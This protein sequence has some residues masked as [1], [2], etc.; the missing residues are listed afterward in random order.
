MSAGRLSVDSAMTSVPSAS[1]A[2]ITTTGELWA[3]A[4]R[5][6]AWLDA[7]GCDS[8]D[9]YD[10]WGTRY[11]RWARRRYYN[12]RRLGGALIA[13]I[14]FIEVICPSLRKLFVSKQRFPTADAQLGLACLN[15]YEARRRLPS[16]IRGPLPDAT[17]SSWL[18][19]AQELAT[20]ILAQ[21]VPGYSG[22]CWGY[23]FD[24]QSVNG[25]VPKSTPH[26]TATPYCYELFAKLWD[27]TGDLSYLNVVRSI[28]AFV[29]RDLKDTPA[30]NDS[31]AS[32]YTPHDHSKVINAS[33]YRAF[34][35]LDAARRFEDDGLKNR[36]LS[37][38]RFILQNQRPD[39]S[40]LYAVDSPAEAFID[41]FHTCFVLKNLYKLNR[42]LRSVEVDG[43][44][45]RGYAWYRQAL[46]DDQDQPRSFAIA[47]RAQIV[48][49][50]MYDVAEA[51]SL[52]VLLRQSIPEGFALADALAARLI[53]HHQLR[54][55]HWLTR[56]YRGGIRHTLPFLRWPQS[57]LFLAV[58]NLLAAL[59]SETPR[60]AQ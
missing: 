34:V 55:G 38:L 20:D 13:P 41:H 21:S 16:E 11:G 3:A 47:P 46:F 9:P 15:L 44:I 19:R 32:S 1:S 30:G 8:Y 28:T 6:T 50:E 40:W 45:R 39:G 51:I 52:G 43:A 24:W 31:A 14:L 54:A 56:V 58:T 37:N 48:N 12:K 27:L 10:I 25:L 36:A 60:Y 7:V 18:K 33:A 5:F 29:S 49:L 2:A 35:L 42:F 23:P 59:E 4:L 57:Q 53:R 22:C 17:A 26:I